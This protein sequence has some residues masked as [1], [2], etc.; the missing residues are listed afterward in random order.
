M[1]IIRKF[2]DKQKLRLPEVRQEMEK[3]LRNSSLAGL[4]DAEFFVETVAYMIAKHLK[5]GSY[6]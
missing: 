4:C 6:R 2:A 3:A 1:D 5:R